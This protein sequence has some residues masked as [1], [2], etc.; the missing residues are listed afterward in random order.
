MKSYMI[1]SPL[2]LS[3][4]DNVHEPD[5]ISIV[6]PISLNRKGDHFLFLWLLSISAVLVKILFF[7]IA[8]SGNQ[9]E[10]LL[11]TK[12]AYPIADEFYAAG[13]YDGLLHFYQ[14]S[15]T[16]NEYADFYD[17]EHYPFLMCYENLTFFREASKK[18]GTDTSS[19]LD[20][21]EV[22]YC[23]LSNRYYQK[24]YPMET[25]DQEMVSAFEDEME[26]FINQLQLTEKEQKDFNDL[27]NSSEYP[28]WEDVEAF[29]KQVYKRLY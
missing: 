27:L 24:G 1:R 20:L 22:F 9:K 11:F 17:W 2:S 25:A 7:N 4:N 23:Y 15:I 5:S 13:D 19:P 26:D 18:L 14:T 29:S 12:E 21:Q 6:I 28:S 8:D 10:V 16:E 3:V